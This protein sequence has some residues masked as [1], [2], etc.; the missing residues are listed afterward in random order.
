MLNQYDRPA[1][2]ILESQSGYLFSTEGW[3]HI[4]YL[5]DIRTEVE[6]QVYVFHFT[7]CQLTPHTALESWEESFPVWRWR[8]A[9]TAVDLPEEVFPTAGPGAFLMSISL[10]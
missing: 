6:L 9:V 4:H 1:N 10:H 5:P 7:G 2:P 8:V 3:P